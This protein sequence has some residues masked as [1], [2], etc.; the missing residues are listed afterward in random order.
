MKARKTMKFQITAQNRITMQRA[1]EDKHEKLFT[2]IY[3][4]HP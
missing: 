2:F 3:D 1:G 4:E